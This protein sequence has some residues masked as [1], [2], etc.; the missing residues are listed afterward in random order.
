MKEITAAIGSPIS[1]E[2]QAVTLL[3]SVP[4]IYS[5]LVTTL[6]SRNNNVKLS[7]VQ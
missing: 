3:G 5:A 7:Y 4:P 1:E 6:E 2:D